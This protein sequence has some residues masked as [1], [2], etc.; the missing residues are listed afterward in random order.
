M[1]NTINKDNLMYVC[2]QED[3]NEIHIV[4][5]EIHTKESKMFDVYNN[6][7]KIVNLLDIE[8]AANVSKPYLSMKTTNNGDCN[9]MTVRV[10]IRSKT[11]YERLSKA[12]LFLIKYKEN[13]L[14]N[15][16]QCGKNT[17][18]RPTFTDDCP[19]S[20]FEVTNQ[21]NCIKKWR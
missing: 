2:D 20:I 4:F 6:C 10:I 7:C 12:K 13:F 19:D 17:V 21:I 5:N 9:M 16:L 8:D 1:F 11:V 3:F 18:I 14:V 15:V